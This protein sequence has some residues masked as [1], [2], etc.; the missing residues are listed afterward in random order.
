MLNSGGVL[1]LKRKAGVSQKGSY[2]LRSYL[3]ALLILFISAALAF[4]LVF[5]SSVSNATL[6]ILR[7]LGSGDL[8]SYEKID[9]SLL[10]ASAKVFETSTS[11]AVAYAEAGTALLSVKEVSEEYFFKERSERMKLETAPNTTTLRSLI[12][13]AE[14]ANKLGVSLGDRVALLMYEPSLNRARPFYMFISGIYSSGY[15]EFDSVVA[16]STSK[17]SDSALIYEI[18]TDNS[19]E[20]KT[21]L[22][23]NGYTVKSAKELYS[24]I[25]SNVNLSVSLLTIIVIFIALL[26]GFFAISI[27]QYYIDRDSRDIASLSLI[28]FSK[29][30]VIA[31]YRKL[32]LITVATSA[33]IGMVIGVLLSFLIAPILSSLDVLKYPALGNYVLSFSVT[34]PYLTLVLLFLALLLSAYLSLRFTLSRYVFV[35]L[36]EALVN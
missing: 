36:K 18:Y 5:V 34:I 22:E 26:A 21:L 11:G 17:L 13:S 35:S 9:E 32:T 25:W 10:P 4:A 33:F 15:S 23:A 1:Y 3:P 27:S 16:Y 12:L 8:V 30:S 6:D 29:K 7:L 14:C 19:E 20:V 2:I 31:I 24:A 28:G